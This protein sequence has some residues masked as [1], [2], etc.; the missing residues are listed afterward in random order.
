MRGRPPSSPL[1]Y[2]YH[3]KEIG[4]VGEII[5]SIL[6]GGFLVLSGVFMNVYLKREEKKWTD[7]EKHSSK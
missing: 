3:R 7:E 5:Y 6:I 1:P 2:R 4:I